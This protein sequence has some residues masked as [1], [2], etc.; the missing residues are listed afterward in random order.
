MRCPVADTFART[1]RMIWI[2]AVIDDDGEI[3]RREIMAAFGISTPQASADLRRYMS[4][5]PGRIAYDRSGKRYMVIE[6]TS[7][8]FPLR[9]RSAAVEV[10]CEVDR[11]SRD[12]EA[13][14]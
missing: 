11:L 2:D 7:P 9:A 14:K 3:G 5:N 12:S 4:K 10:V 6:G 8:L 1:V 13:P